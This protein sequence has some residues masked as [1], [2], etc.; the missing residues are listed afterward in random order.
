[1]FAA[2]SASAAPKDRKDHPDHPAHPEHP[3]KH[4]SVPEPATLALFGIGLV[5]FVLSRR[6]RK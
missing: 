6:N 3:T 5:G 1:M 4:V 2:A